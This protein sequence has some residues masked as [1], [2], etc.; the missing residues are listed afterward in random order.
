MDFRKLNN[1]T[2]NNSYLSTI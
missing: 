1:I 2:V